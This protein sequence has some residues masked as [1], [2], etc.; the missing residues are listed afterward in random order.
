MQQA[1]KCIT[2][3]QSSEGIKYDESLWKQQHGNDLVVINCFASKIFY[4]EHWTPLSLKLL[5]AEKNIISYGIQR[6]Q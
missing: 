4:P 6:I 5:L 2:D 3:F 1:I